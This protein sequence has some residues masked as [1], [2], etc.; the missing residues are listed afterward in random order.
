ML[1]RIIGSALWAI[2]VGVT[3][4]II[5]NAMGVQSNI[6]TV[7]GTLGLI[8]AS[9]GIY[10]AAD[11]VHDRAP[12]A[13][14]VSMLI[15]LAGESF[16]IPSEIN[17]WSATISAK[18]DQEAD[19]AHKAND[20]RMILDKEAGKLLTE[21]P[22]RSAATVQAE[23]DGEL[24]KVYSGQTLAKA[25]INCTDLESIAIW[26]CKAVLTLRRE[27]AA[28]QSYEKSTSL[29][30]NANTTTDHKAAHG[31]HDGPEQLADM[32]GGTSKH[33][34]QGLMVVT[35]A[36]LFLTRGLGLYVGWRRS[37]QRR[38]LTIQARDITALPMPA[39]EP[40]ED[41]QP[42]LVAPVP[43]SSEP[44][45]TKVFDETNV[46]QIGPRQA[47]EPK[48][49]PM[50]DPKSI[51]GIVA[52]AARSMGPGEQPMPAIMQAVK[53]LA[54][55]RS[56]TEV[57]HPTKVGVILSHKLGY[58]SRRGTPKEGRVT[59]YDFATGSRQETCVA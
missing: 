16:I 51:E 57:P 8:A 32:L 33:W 47:L 55:A 31:T 1:R 14:M 36:L 5:Y 7:I 34:A 43:I 38:M 46:V 23:I 28:A 42:V 44:A 53:A 29:V 10:L 30:W 22:A 9:T 21:K 39:N 27:L 11:A 56:V 54:E 17:Y 20:R 15:W 52:A 41:V 25:T 24:A 6:L 37:P 13:F 35:I 2:S 49:A 48:L 40:A 19:A 59:I 45:I 18:A 26:R 50:I 58:S 12:I 3:G 4:A